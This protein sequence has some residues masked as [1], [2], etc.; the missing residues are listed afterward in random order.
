MTKDFMSPDRELPSRD[1]RN[2]EE[3]LRQQELLFGGG[4]DFGGAGATGTF[5][6]PPI[7]GFINNQTPAETARLNRAGL[8]TFS[9]PDNNY[10]H[11]GNNIVTNSVDESLDLN[12]KIQPNVLDNYDNVTYHWKLFITTPEASSSGDILN[13]SN[14]TIIAETSVTDLTIDKVEIRGVA[15]P[16]IESGTGMS[17]HVKFEIMEPSGAGLIDKLFYQSVAL[18]IGNWVTMPVYLQLQFKNRKPDTS[19]VDDGT[20]GSLANLRWIWTLSITRTKANITSSGTRYEFEGT[21]YNELAQ[22]NANFTLQHNTVLNKLDTFSDA[23]N[24]LQDKLNEDQFLKL[25]GNYSIPDS[26]KIIVDPKIA[27]FKITPVDKSTDSVR[28]DNFVTYGLKDASFSS[29]TAIDKVIDSLLAQTGEYQKSMLN[30]PTPGADGAPMN[31]EVSQMKKFWRII[32]ET[33]PLQFDPL[34]QNVAKEYTIFVI[35]YDLGV[36]DANA[37][38]TTAGPQTLAAERKRLATYVK[39]SILKKLYN[40]IFTGL[41]DQ[42]IDFD[43][44]IN[45]AFAVSQ[46]R[47]NGIYLNAAMFDK[48][49]VT[50]NHSAD[51]S[52]I[53]SEISAT[54][55]LQNN[56]KTPIQVDAAIAAAESTQKSIDA[57][58]LPLETKKRYSVLLSKSK[59]ESRMNFLSEIRARGGLNNDGTLSSI[60]SEST[61]LAKPI[62]EKITQQQ[63]NFISDVNIE[64]QAAKSAYTALMENSKGKLRPIARVESMQD[65]QIG[66]GIISS[67]NS[68]IQKLSNMFSVALHSGLD[69]SFQ[70]IRMRIKGDPFW[71]FPQP[72]EHTN[73][74]IFNSL[75]SKE[76]AIDSIKRGHFNYADSANFYGTDN[77]LIVRFRSPKIYNVDEN[78]DSIDPNTDIES[79]SGVFKVLEVTNIFGVGK[80]EQELVCILDPEIRL[81]NFMSQINAASATKNVPTAPAELITKNALPLPLTAIKTQKI[82]GTLD[83]KGIENQARTLTGQVKELGSKTVGQ[84]VGSLSN[85]PSPT[86]LTPD[87]ILIRRGINLTGP[88]G[89]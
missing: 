51:E 24:E 12:L 72:I 19:E 85:V 88:T 57:S 2:H 65:L 17:T 66:Q 73:A 35:E 39:K 7:K 16:T 42:I 52:K 48:G 46:S 53:T 61:N 59:P 58:D 40:Y 84:A 44:S 5:P 82:M 30:A 63:F 20:I 32:T 69:G 70:R 78:P 37:S 83:I 36:L 71:L 62:R 31:Q 74:K 45:N 60:R 86:N 9:Q 81:L 33:R 21:I 38:Q 75:K 80:F 4:G 67:S 41:N 28:N 29:G 89:A 10:S 23:M 3:A 14:Q 26:F 87:E 13:I 8:P 77:F 47:F 54:I 1:P 43:L 15:T 64:S 11:E 22:S 27:S 79:F 49:A 76:E 6:E 68:G 25:L 55:S 34:R 50:H 56:A 18:G